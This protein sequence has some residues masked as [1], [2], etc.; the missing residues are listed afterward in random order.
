[1]GSNEI[2]PVLV[3]TDSG[4]D[5]AVALFMVLEAHR[6][7]LINVVAITTTHGNTSI[8]NVNKNVLRLLETVGML[9]VSYFLAILLVFAFCECLSLYVS[10]PYQET[11]TTQNI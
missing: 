11:V 8:K 9:D 3:D 10:I 7:G 1:M 6:R 2:P 5:D 4:L